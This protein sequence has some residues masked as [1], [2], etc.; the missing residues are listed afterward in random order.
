VGDD[1]MR[2]GFCEAIEEGLWVF[3]VGVVFEEALKKETSFLGNKI[4][5]DVV[6]LHEGLDA[7]E[8]L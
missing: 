1:H 7:V 6:F 2:G 5:E 4:F 3:V 8:L